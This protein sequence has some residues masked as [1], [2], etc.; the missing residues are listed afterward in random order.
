MLTLF[1]GLMSGLTVGYLSI[2][3]LD[4]KLKI[5]N[6]TPDTVQYAKRVLPIIEQHHYLLVTLLLANAAAMET[7][8]IFLDALVPSV[9]AIMISVTAVLFFGEI[10]PQA[11]CTGPNQLK[12]AASVAPLVQLLMVAEGILAYPLAKLLDFVLGEHHMIRYSN[13]DLKGL[14]ELHTEKALGGGP[15]AGDSEEGLR[16]YQTLAIQGA[17]DLAKKNVKSVMVPVKKVFML[18]TNKALDKKRVKQLLK[19]GYSRIPVYRSREKH[20]ILGILHIKSLIGLDLTSERTLG[21]L[22]EEGEIVLRKPSFVQPS[23]DLGSL[24]KEFMKGRS[25]LAIVSNRSAELREW[26]ENHSSSGDEAGGGAFPPELEKDPAPEEG[27]VEG[28]P[29]VLGLVTLE[30][31]IEEMLNEE[32][33]DEADYDK[34]HD[35]YGRHDSFRLDKSAVGDTKEKI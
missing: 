11:V 33:L 27:K 1:A 22:I 14:V 13:S 24:L 34:Q 6:G 18:S 35:V 9:Y 8:P 21:K 28:A 12:I 32:I 16:P 4:M 25:H 26:N 29:D 3:M 17:I 5:Q 31:V 19:H 20:N 7:L 15:T 2:D 10:I 23:Q 30:D